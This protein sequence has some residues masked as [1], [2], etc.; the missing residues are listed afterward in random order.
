MAYRLYTC[1]DKKSTVNLQNYSCPKYPYD[2]FIILLEMIILVVT[3]YL[4]YIRCRTKLLE[5]TTTTAQVTSLQSADKKGGEAKNEKSINTSKKNTK[6][7]KVFFV[8]KFFD[9]Q[10]LS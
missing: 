4:L 8:V 6:R 1:M 3:L 7:R 10:I 2:H 5:L 9:E